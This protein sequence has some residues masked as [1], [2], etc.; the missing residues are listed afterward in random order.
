MTMPDFG[1]AFED[2][3]WDER[4][5]SSSQDFDKYMQAKERARIKAEEEQVFRKPFEPR[6]HV[7][8]HPFRDMI[9]SLLLKADLSFSELA[10]RMPEARN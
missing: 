6:C 8:T 10:R 5:S 9:D 3:E 4:D 7:C 2:E 1:A